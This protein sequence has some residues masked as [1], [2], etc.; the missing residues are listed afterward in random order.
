MF[1]SKMW[2]WFPPFSSNEERWHSFAEKRLGVVLLVYLG[3]ITK[4]H[5]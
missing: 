1:F 3:V 4:T 5:F 2:A